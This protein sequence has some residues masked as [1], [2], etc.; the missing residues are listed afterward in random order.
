VPADELGCFVVAPV[1]AGP[2]RLRVEY[3]GRVVQ[4]TWVSYASL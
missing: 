4:T 2:V 1:P 3:A